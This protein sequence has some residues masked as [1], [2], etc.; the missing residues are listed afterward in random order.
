MTES[1]RAQLPDTEPT[2]DVR[3]P[4]P[5]VA[6]IVLGGEHDLESA[7]L[8]E[9]AA[10]DV[11]LTGFHLIVDLSPVQFIDSSIINLL[12]RLRN[13]ANANNQRFNLV[14]G[15]APS[16]RRTLEICGVMQVLNCVP[17]VD[18]ALTESMTTPGLTRNT[19]PGSPGMGADVR[20]GRRGVVE[21]AFLLA[22]ASHPG[23]E[24]GDQ[25]TEG[26][27]EQ[28]EPDHP[29]SLTDEDEIDRDLLRV[30]DDQQKRIDPKCHQDDCL[31]ADPS[32]A[33]VG[34]LR[35]RGR[36]FPIA[37]LSHPRHEP[38]DQRS[39]S[40]AEQNEVDHPCLL[41]EEDEVDRDGSRVLNDQ[42]KRVNPQRGQE[43]RLPAET[44]GTTSLPTSLGSPIARRCRL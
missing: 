5:D 23:N 35:I 41:T 34:P 21:S 4:R 14:V 25:G 30:Q 38:R 10:D 7:P 17:S 19:G 1:L 20:S 31:P 15:T 32:L 28:D 11:L 44:A 36:A 29:R 2:I 22:S 33:A 9:R 13:D 37:T 8:V 42:Q 26:H 40:H 27:A 6:L 24:P 43:D 16:V 3:R 18:A 12:V 39:Q